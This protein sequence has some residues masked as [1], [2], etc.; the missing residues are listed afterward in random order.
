MVRWAGIVLAHAAPGED[1]MRSRLATALHPVAGRPLVW[2]T[3]AALAGASPAPESVL[4]TTRGEL[5]AEHFDGIPVPVRVETLEADDLVQLARPLAEQPADAVVVADATAALLRGSLDALIGAGRSRWLG[6]GDRVAAALVA[7]EKIGELLRLREPLL[8][9]SGVLAAPDRLPDADD[10]LL[11]RD[12]AALARVTR[13]IR[14][15]IVRRHMDAGVTFLLPDTVL[16]DQDV[17]I[18][19][20][21]VVYPH[22]VLEGQTTVGEETVIGPGCRVLDSWVGSG[23]ELKG[24]NF[25]A[26][27]SVRNRAILEPYVRRGYD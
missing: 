5:G 18:G 20:D 21:T 1:A 10:A 19:S 24:W 17:R 22:V 8:A 11:V 14:D 25:I 23:V 27:T 15:R 12:R 13:E 2:H 4:V 6:A 26:N 7:G 3:A 16:V 9:P